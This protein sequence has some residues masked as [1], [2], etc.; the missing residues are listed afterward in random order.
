MANQSIYPYGTDGQLPSNIGIINDLVTGGADKALSAEQGK[1]LNEKMQSTQELDFSQYVIDN[2]TI[3]SD[4]GASNYYNKWI[5]ASGFKNALIPVVPGETVEIKGHADTYRTAYAV[6]TTDSHQS[7][8]DA[9]FAT[10]YTSIV[11]IALDDIVQI[12]IPANGAFLF[13]TIYSTADV[14]PQ[15]VKTVQDKFLTEEDVSEMRKTVEGE[16]QRQVLPAEVS[17]AIAANTNKWVVYGQY[18]SVLIPVSPGDVFKITANDNYICPFAVLASDSHTSNTVPDY[19]TGFTAL[20]NIA[21]GETEFVTIPQDG[22]YLYLH[23][24]STHSLAPKSIF[25]VTAISLEDKVDEKMRE[26]IE[27][28]ESSKSS[29]PEFL[30]AGELTNVIYTMDDFILENEYDPNASPIVDNLRFSK[31]LGKTWVTKANEFGI[32]TNV[33]LFAD[34]T[35][36]VGSKKD[37][38]CRLYWTR[39]LDTFVFQ[40]VSSI[41]DYDG[42]AYTP[43]AGETRFFTTPPPFEHVYID[44]KEVYCFWDYIIPGN[45]GTSNARAWY[46]T[47]DADGVHVRSA[48]AFNLSTIDGVVIRARHIHHFLYNKYN[49]YYYIFTGDHMSG[50]K[51]EC[52]ILKGKPDANHVWT[53]EVVANGQEY[54]LIVPAFDEGNLYAVTDYT[55]SSL[56]NEKGVFMCP[57]DDIRKTRFRYLFKATAAFMAEGSINSAVGLAWYM[58]DNHG[59]RIIKTDYLG[60]SKILLAHNDHNFVWVDNSTGKRFTYLIGPNN[61]GD[62]YARFNNV[63]HSV[64]GEAWLLWNHQQTYNF[65]EMMRKAGATDF[66]KDWHTLLY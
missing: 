36:M 29:F 58:A 48:F 62:V 6:L 23:T 59:W 63:G 43:V 44:G 47:S 22:A 32:I 2:I 16:Y 31:D 35:L 57:V 1:V 60:N 30:E 14:S 49:G 65:T 8:T 50:S 25:K 21:V 40:E 18:K 41:I 27:E 10:G 4:S 54:K 7:G 64:S 52:Y 28:S 19:A 42:N 46:A 38:G 34:G 3:G 56:A 17:Y 9:S 53:W 37:D 11:R 33:F 39:D 13:V 12:T 26:L 45:G 55:D 66:F 15:S 20:R 51:S 5:S 61:N 24:Y